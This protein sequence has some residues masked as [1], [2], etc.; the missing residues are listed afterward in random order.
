MI[1]GR[2]AGT[3]DW[4]Q[5]VTDAGAALIGG[6]FGGL[7]GG[8]VAAYVAISQTRETLAH[9]AEQARLAAKEERASQRA[10]VDR[11]AALRLLQVLAEFVRHLPQL[12]LA[13]VPMMGMGEQVP[14]DARH[15]IDVLIDEQQATVISMPLPVRQRWEHLCRLAIELGGLGAFDVRDAWPKPRVDRARGDVTN[16][17]RFVRATLVAVID[18]KELPRDH[19]PPVLDRNPSDDALWRHPDEQTWGLGG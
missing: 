13:S 10:A 1:I 8:G 9:D 4:W 19:L 5:F 15:A 16:Y 7:A 17:V 6:V 18:G 14:L 11:S 2:A 3:W 12:H